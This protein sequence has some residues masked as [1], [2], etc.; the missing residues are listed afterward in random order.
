MEPGI[1]GAAILAGGG[2]CV[3]LTVWRFSSRAVRTPLPNA[4]HDGPTVD[5]SHPRSQ[6]RDRQQER[7]GPGVRGRKGRIRLRTHPTHTTD[8]ATTQNTRNTNGFSGGG[9]GATPDGGFRSA[10]R[11]LHPIALYPGTR[12]QGEFRGGWKEVSTP[13]QPAT[14]RTRRRPR[15]GARPPTS[16]L[17]A[18]SWRR[19]AI[20]PRTRSSPV[21]PQPARSSARP[22]VARPP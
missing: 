13:W 10:F 19:A 12:R 18:P 2:R 6:N 15:S 20:A 9:G 3:R 5:I 21:V 8:A 1:A 11:S 22:S 17:A 16:G 7:N 14:R 4:P